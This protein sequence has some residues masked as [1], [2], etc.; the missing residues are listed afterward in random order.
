MGFS[1]RS[2]GLRWPCLVV[3][4]HRAH[5]ISNSKS[6]FVCSHFP[7]KVACNLHI[8]FPTALKK[9]FVVSQFSFSGESPTWFLVALATRV[10]FAV[11]CDQCGRT[12]CYQ[13]RFETQLPGKSSAQTVGHEESISGGT[14]TI[15]AGGCPN[16]PTELIFPTRTFGIF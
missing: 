1:K 8:F 5:H 16:H 4:T 2:G 15:R 12:A 13:T 14:R 10:A 3:P 7:L 9:G 6:C 11:E